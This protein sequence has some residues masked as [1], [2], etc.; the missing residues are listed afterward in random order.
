MVVPVTFNGF[1]V[2]PPEVSATNVVL[3]TTSRLPVTFNTS[4]IKIKSPEE[5]VIFAGLPVPLNVIVV[6]AP[7]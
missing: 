5:A 7:A 2:P 1:T 4:A 3:D 6:P